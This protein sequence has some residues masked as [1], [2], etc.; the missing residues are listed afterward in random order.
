MCAEEIVEVNRFFLVDV[1]RGDEF[2]TFDGGRLEGVVCPGGNRQEAIGRDE[3][4]FF[5]DKGGRESEIDARPVFGE[6]YGED[7]SV[8]GVKDVLV[9]LF[10]PVFHDGEGHRSVARSRGA[11]GK[12]VCDIAIPHFV[13]KGPTVVGGTHDPGGSGRVAFSRKRE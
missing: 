4:V 9:R 12:D 8:G 10:V 5:V 6:A 2:K 11:V 7:S 3:A 1:R 13:V